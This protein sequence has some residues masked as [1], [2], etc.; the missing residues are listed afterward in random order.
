PHLVD[1]LFSAD[2]GLF[3]WSPIA[4][5]GLLGLVAGFRRAPVVHGGALLVWAATAW[6]NGSVTD[7]DWAAGD[8]FGAR[9]FDLVVPLLAWG[10]A[11]L[12]RALRPALARA[13][14]RAAAARASSRPPAPPAPRA[15]RRST[16]SRPTRPASRATPRSSGRRRSRA[17]AV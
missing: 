12:L 10:L 17:R 4:W 16:R 1:V 2:H 6:V 7:W 11:A 5:L 9:R 15:P 13:P 14:L 3:A 8:A